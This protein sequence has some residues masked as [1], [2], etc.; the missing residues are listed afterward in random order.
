MTELSPSLL[1]AVPLAPLVGAVVAGLFGK[2]VGRRG[3]HWITCLGVAVAF[4]LSVQ[5]L[6]AVTAGARFNATVYEWLV[7]G[8]LKMEYIE[9][10]P[11]K[12]WVRY[13]AP[14]WTYSGIAMLAMPSHVRRYNGR[15]WHARNGLLLG[16]DRL[17]YVKTKTITEGEPYDEGFFIEHDKPVPPDECARLLAVAKRRKKQ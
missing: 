10:S 4:V 12:C 7:I 9:E 15:S 14:M 5:T 11:K 8:G 2:A 6:L 16:N 3:A 17:Q 13:L 1:T